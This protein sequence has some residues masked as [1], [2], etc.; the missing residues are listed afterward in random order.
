MSE[1][2]AILLCALCFF[3][4]A[5]LGYAI[6]QYRREK[7]ETVV[8]APESTISEEDLEKIRKEREEMKAEQAAFLSMVG[9]NADIAYGLGKSPF[10]G[11]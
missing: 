5:V 9:Y 6:G 10:E 2:V 11:S 1:A 8:R 7:K 4:G 3:N